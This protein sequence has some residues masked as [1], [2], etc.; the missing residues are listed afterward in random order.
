MQFARAF[1][2][3]KR[4]SGRI[5]PVLGS[6]ASMCPRGMLFE[7][8]IALLMGPKSGGA[9][10]TPQGEWKG[11]LRTMCVNKAPAGEKAATKPLCALSRAVYVTQIVWEPS[12]AVMV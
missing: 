9:S 11:P 8:R 10:A 5:P 12:A 6:N 3:E 4:R 1:R 7:I 2:G